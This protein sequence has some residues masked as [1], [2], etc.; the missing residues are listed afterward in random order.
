MAAVAGSEAI[1]QIL[2]KEGVEYVFGI[3]GSTEAQ[4]MDTLYDHPE[5]KYILCLHET[6][7]LAMAEG[8]ARASGKVGFLNLHTAPGL[9]SAMSMMIVAYIGG[10]PL[11]ITAGQQDTRLLEYEPELA[12]DLKSIA[13]Q[14]TKWSTEVRYAADLPTVLRRAFKVATQPPTGPVFVSL[15]N[16]VLMQTLDFNYSTGTRLYT[17]LRPDNEAVKKAAGL[18]AEARKPAMIVGSGIAKYEAI[19]EAVQLAELLGV[20]VYQTWASDV[21]FPTEHGLFLGDLRTSSLQTRELLKSVDVLVVISNPLFRQPIFFPESLLT[22]ATRI[23]QVDDNPWELEKNIPVDSTLQGDIKVCLS[24]LIELLQQTMSDKARNES[25]ARTME[26]SRE[27]E[28]IREQVEKKAQGE[29]DKVPISV[30]RLGKELGNCLKPGT[31][32]VDDTWSESGTLRSMIDFS[33]PGSYV[34]IRGGGTIGWGIPASMGTKLATPDRQVIAA[35]GDGGAIFSIQGLWTAAHYNIPVK[36]VIFS[37]G[38]YGMVKFTKMLQMGENAKE[39]FLALDLHP[40]RMDFTRMAE[41][42]GVRGWKVESPDTLGDILKTALESD[43]P[44]LIE[45]YIEDVI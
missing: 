31:V 16:D 12:G 26:V 11:I 21:T 41:A 38:S 9:T 32:L 37:N 40:P 7:A 23:I 5:I 45:V 22:P 30:S 8:Y 36:F 35:L 18:L 44:E 25:R 20:R 29:K 24:E 1:M 34:R 33:E 19:P 39:R 28:K 17:Q 10:I 43:E 2:N 3:P 4:F 14:Y 13:R 15:P 6:V 27:K 42:M